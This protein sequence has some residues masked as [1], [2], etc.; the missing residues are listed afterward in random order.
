MKEYQKGEN[1]PWQNLCQSGGMLLP[2]VKHW[3]LP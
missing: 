2:P 3:R 1:Y